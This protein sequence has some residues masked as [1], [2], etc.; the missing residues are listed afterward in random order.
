M[1]ITTLS[2][3]FALLAAA[4]STSATVPGQPEGVK[5]IA[6]STDSAF[7]NTDTPDEKVWAV[8]ITPDHCQAWLRDDGA[9]GMALARL[10]PVSGKVVCTKELPA[11]A[12]IG[13]YNQAGLIDILP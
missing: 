11:G 7:W 4:C 9:E 3:T 8:A 13:D 5:L 12:V 6:R 2:M 1:K 10:D